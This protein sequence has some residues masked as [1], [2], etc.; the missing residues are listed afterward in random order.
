MV[1]IHCLCVHTIDV[2]TL[3]GFI[4]DF[5]KGGIKCVRKNVTR[6]LMTFWKFNCTQLNDIHCIHHTEF[7]NL[8][9]GGW[10]NL[11]GVNIPGPP[12]SV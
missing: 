5:R 1:G 2:H 7:Q 3:Q 9:G 12:P 11:A 4:H 8:G 10:G 6:A